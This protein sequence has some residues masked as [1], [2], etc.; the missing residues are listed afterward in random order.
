[1]EDLRKHCK[2]VLSAIE[3]SNA[4][5]SSKSLPPPSSANGVKSTLPSSRPSTSKSGPPSDS[6]DSILSSVLGKIEFTEDSVIPL[7][8]SL[9]EAT[10]TLRHVLMSIQSSVGKKIVTGDDDVPLFSF[11]ADTSVE[12][13]RRHCAKVLKRGLHTFCSSMGQIL[14]REKSTGS[15]SSS[16]PSALSKSGSD[17][18]KCNGAVHDDAVKGSGSDVPEVR[19]TSH[20]DRKSEKKSKTAEREDREKRKQKEMESKKKDKEEK[21]KRDGREG[22]NRK[23]ETEKHRSEKSPS[24]K[25]KN[26]RGDE[27]EIEE[28]PKGDQS[29]SDIG[30]EQKVKKTKRDKQ[31]AKKDSC[32]RVKTV[33]ENDSESIEIK[34]ETESSELP[35]SEEYPETE[36]SHR[37]EAVCDDIEND[38]SAPVSS[39]QEEAS[40]IEE[41]LFAKLELIQELADEFCKGQEK[42]GEDE[43]DSDD[44]DSE[45]EP[46]PPVSFGVAF[47]DSSEKPDS[48][49]EA[50]SAPQNS[51]KEVTIKVVDTSD[52]ESAVHDEKSPKLKSTPRKQNFANKKSTKETNEDVSGAL[53]KDNKTKKPSP[54]DVEKTDTSQKKSESDSEH[55]D[56]SDLIMSCVEDDDERQAKR[57]HKQKKRSKFHL[58]FLSC[59]YVTFLFNKF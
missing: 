5:S 58:F 35:V 1:M 21:S 12:K 47:I 38:I 27:E 49:Q 48:D 33:S 43:G 51:G 52:V 19:T 28:D 10:T 34:L 56:S 41:N 31:I 17:V 54:R 24:K 45:G 36:K 59:P 13:K 55:V 26:V 4:K 44:V 9:L 16:V 3:A 30:E 25:R 7:T 39:S 29:D 11:P 42:G 57:K 46:L 40:Q 18:S 37:P 6:I 8:D 32:K 22:R 2:E 53:K 14:N 15:Y 50:E 23:E 20:K